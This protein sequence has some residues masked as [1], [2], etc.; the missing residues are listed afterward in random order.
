MGRAEAADGMTRLPVLDDQG[1]YFV[2]VH[3]SAHAISHLLFGIPMGGTSVVPEPG[4][5][6]RVAAKQTWEPEIRTHLILGSEPHVRQRVHDRIISF[7]AGDAAEALAKAEA[8]VFHTGYLPETWEY[9]KAL[10]LADVLSRSPE[11]GWALLAWLD[12]RAK[13]IVSN[14]WFRKIQ[15]AIVP[16]L[17]EE[18]DLTQDEIVELVRPIA[19]DI[20]DISPKTW[21]GWL[22]LRLL[23]MARPFRRAFRRL[24]RRI[25][26]SRKRR[27]QS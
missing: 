14:H 25:M 17:L 4:T 8:G 11:E 5:L 23:L 20:L 6:G 21:R 16:T 18:G 13:D 7:L 10:E 24:K 3:E 15:S 2:A 12:Y 26:W 22:R 19:A 1:R 9:K 27:T